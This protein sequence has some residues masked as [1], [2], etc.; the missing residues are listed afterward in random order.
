MVSP[1]ILLQTVHHTNCYKR[2]TTQ[3]VTNGSPHKLLQTVHHTK[4]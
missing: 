3:T 2:F 4:C 1:N